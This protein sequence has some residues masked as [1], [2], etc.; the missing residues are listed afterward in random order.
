VGKQV[1]SAA[2]YLRSILNFIEVQ[3]FQVVTDSRSTTV[4]KIVFKYIIHNIDVK[5]LQNLSVSEF[6]AIFH[7]REVNNLRINKKKITGQ[8]QQR[9]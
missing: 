1:A 9:K 5:I 2:Y 7:P 3:D 4:K 8:F 6:D